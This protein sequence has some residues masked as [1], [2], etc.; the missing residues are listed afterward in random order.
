MAKSKP[1]NA[2]EYVTA[3][4]VETEEKLEQANLHI[5]TLEEDLETFRADMLRIR[6][7]FKIEPSSISKEYK[8]VYYKNPENE[9]DTDIIAW[10]GSLKE[11]EF[12]D[13]FK[14]LMQILHLEL[15]VDDDV[16]KDVDYALEDL[17]D[18][19]NPENPGDSNDPEDSGEV[20]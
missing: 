20:K 7:T 6:E 19:K 16:N 1:I 5:A 18:P 9:W 15:P 3:R 10:S 12:R 17:K 8:I 13:E 14:H 4:L 11:E 2:D